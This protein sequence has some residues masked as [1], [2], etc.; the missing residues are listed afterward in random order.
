MKV[1]D[2]ETKKEIF[3][4]LISQVEN[5]YRLYFGLKSIQKKLDY[6]ES[7]YDHFQLDAEDGLTFNEESD[8]PKEIRDEVLQVYGQV[9]L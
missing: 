1:A 6:T 5:D 9:Y 8:L 7:I 4:Q 3:H 2:L